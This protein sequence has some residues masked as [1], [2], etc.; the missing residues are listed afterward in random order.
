MT[1]QLL[2]SEL[3]TLIQESKRKNPDLR[4][5]AEKALNDLKALPNTS[6]AQLT[7]GEVKV[8][9]ASSISDFIRSPKLA[10]SGVNGLLRITV[11]NG[12]SPD[13]LRDV[14][15]AFRDCT[16]LGLDVQLK[17][18]QALPSL[19]QNYAENLRGK[20]LIF[21]FQV[22]FA[23]HS[24]KTGVVSNTAAASLQQLL[25]FAFENVASEDE[26]PPG[27]MA[28]VTL[29]I[30]KGPISLGRNASDA[31]HLLND[32]CLLTEGS[33]P[34][35]LDGASLTP[36]FGL[37]LIESLLVAHID[38]VAKHVED[39]YV[40]R[41]RLMPLVVSV[42]SE[43]A[44]FNVTVRTVRLLRL[45][46]RKLLL[47]M[48]AEIEM[49]MS[50][51][52]HL[53]DPNT[54]VVWKRALYLE[55]LQDIHDDAALI[56]SLF[57]YFDQDRARKSLVGD[58]L[59]VLVRVAAEKPAVIGLGQR[60]S[61]IETQHN[62]PAEHIAIEAGGLSGAVGILT[63]EASLNKQ[64][65]SAKWSTVRTA[66]IDQIDKIEPPALPATYL[67][68]LV[69]TCIN[70]F[71]D[72]L[73][74]FLLP[75]SIPN[76]TK[77]KRK[78]KS[79][80][81]QQSQDGSRT[82]DNGEPKPYHPTNSTSYEKNP[83]VN[84]LTLEDH[85]KYDHIRTSSLIVEHSWPALL[86]TWSTFLNASLDS[87]YYHALIRSVQRL[88]QV[89]G[90]LDLS[91]PRDAFLTTLAKH[92]VPSA[93]AGSMKTPVLGTSKDREMNG[94]S[95]DDESKRSHKAVSWTSSETH[96]QS[97][98]N[99]NLR[100]LL[101]LRALLNLG[102]AL[103]PVL[104][105]SWTIIFES[106]YQV[107]AILI[108][109]SH[110]SVT[111]GSID[112]TDVH[113]TPELDELNAEKSAV[114]ASVSRLFESTSGLPN[115][116]FSQALKCSCSLV[117]SVSGVP[118]GG[119]PEPK[120][121]AQGEVS[122]QVVT[123]RH[124][125]LRS[126]SGIRMSE[127]VTGEDC[128]ISIERTAQMIQCNIPRISRAPSSDSGWASFSQML[129]DHLCFSTVIPEV[130]IGAARNLIEIIR[131]LTSFARRNAP[132]LQNKAISQSLEALAAAVSCLWH[133]KVTK[134]GLNC[135][136]EI[137]S[138]VLGALLSILEQCGEGLSSGWDTVFFLINS[139]FKQAQH[140][141]DNDDRIMFEVAA[142]ASRSPKL[143]RSAFAA[144]QLICSDFLTSIPDQCFLKLLDTQHRFCSQSDD[145]N[146][147]LTSMALF[148]NV[149][150]FLQRDNKEMAQLLIDADVAQCIGAKELVDIINAQ[151][152]RVSKSALWVGLVLHLA[153]LF[154]DNRLEVRHSA[155]H[156]LFGLFDACGDRLVVEA[157]R[158]SFHLVFFQLLSL[159]KTEFIRTE[160]INDTD[161]RG[162]DESAVLLVRSISKQLITSLG[163]L[164][165]Q[166]ALSSV[167]EQLL[168]KYASL[169]DR[170]SLDL[171]RAVFSSLTE[172]L[173][174]IER[175]SCATNI[176][177]DAAWVIWTDNDP[178]SYDNQG[179]ADNNDTLIAYLQY[180]RQVH[181]LLSDELDAAQVVAL[182]MNLEA[183]ISRSSAS[184]YGSD[185]DEMTA[186]QK[187]ALE[188]M[189]MIPTS[190]QG[191]LARCVQAI[192]SLVTLAFQSTDNSSHKSKTNVALSKASMEVLENMMKQHSVKAHASSANLLATTFLAL[193]VPVGLK[194][195]WKREGKGTPT[196]KKA[197]STFLSIL[198]ADTIRDCSGSGKEKQSMWT[199]IVDMGDSI[200]A[201][202]IDAC[203]YPAI[204][205]ADQTFD[206]ES[207][208]R[209]QS[210]IIPTLGSP[211]IPDKI[212]RRYVE[213]L[214]Q[215]SIIHEPHPD[216]LARPDQEL[217]DGLRSQHVGRVQDLPPKR[218][219]KM[220]YV[221]S[222][223]LFDLATV[224]DGS[225]KRVR[226]AQIAAP[227]LILRVGLV[228]K[229]YICDQPLRG[230]M[231][232][233]LSQKREMH[234]VLEKLV[235]LDLE[236]KAI[237]ET[238]G[239][240]SEHK[241][242]LFLL[243]GLITKALKAAR[244]DEGMQTALTKV[245]DTMGLNF[246][247]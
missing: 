41:T 34:K 104:Q 72:G 44:G 115:Q 61:G 43:K 213:S 176:S 33:P 143:V 170:Q 156:T 218:R 144:L 16:T 167:W 30:Q 246:A 9:L 148:R 57:S 120:I 87:E 127:A 134:G 59:A 171:S 133:S 22:C 81:K 221:L 237:P 108:A 2:S 84:P 220:A 56:R 70:R 151:D 192:A 187:L 198:D 175:T 138:M 243:F 247:L 219:S 160:D 245:L 15:Q 141:A 102:T 42:L 205:S 8:S 184:A 55:F 229:A 239:V 200:M 153:H 52:N 21:A 139:V 206:I 85:E 125:L 119:T 140:R 174:Q 132:A 38:T 228:L 154:R 17:V 121:T 159:T 36:E 80:A 146:V 130:R 18:L 77:P 197:T 74:K 88:T 226:L 209:L 223:Q 64:G 227:Y 6:E 53:L 20:L 222:D 129:I 217:L 105:D 203:E 71:S 117:Y 89:A 95:D 19:L 13:S 126:T 142:S 185:V 165:E 31:Y 111:Q 131:H 112:P 149:S 169:L 182:I 109:T 110:R 97:S 147:A 54:S 65:I 27:D 48:P 233:P 25:A 242:H 76:E 75:F 244:R 98:P 189:I 100:N 195:R 32:L 5:A 93:T 92:A 50:L 150:D 128:L 161:R 199:A 116:A 216:D 178:T 68:S 215:R 166:Q 58:Q 47:A 10:A 26:L 208:S 240:Q 39:I 224:H 45:L 145:L 236:P 238:S 194:Y 78:Q 122:S 210:I 230:L 62:L 90:L 196:W 82:D 86:A 186:V 179:S 180:I 7:A 172:V 83:P 118:I 23:L 4:H 188:N 137:H 49:A 103:G 28:L 124:H 136:L 96:K 232:Q 12:L 11:S 207:F 123:P 94:T 235:E 40:L 37:E 69:L 99:L 14:L 183:C 162:W 201:A 24:S 91:T 66:C 212:R 106:L 73:A 51:I 3:T 29:P 193:E 101:C 168:A 1:S 60:S 67:Y 225:V 135:S 114:E 113:E 214:F 231:P 190:S 46:V 157:W 35:V 152:D 163:P 181:V 204:I 155:L 177:L 107:D 79:A 63:D 211:S 234:H 158:M 164:S 202:D 173:A 241:K 191:V